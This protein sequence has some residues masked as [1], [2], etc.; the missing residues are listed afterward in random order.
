[1]G[2]GEAVR[3]M[4]STYGRRVVAARVEQGRKRWAWF[5]RLA[6][7]TAAAVLAACAGGGGGL[8]TATV[9]SCMQCHNATLHGD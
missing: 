5:R 9:S 7:G 8:Q 6:L 2:R 3:A 4:A 1:M